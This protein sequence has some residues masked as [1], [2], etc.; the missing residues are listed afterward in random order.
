MEKKSVSSNNLEKIQNHVTIKD[1][2]ARAGV[3]IGTVDRALHNRG[4]ISEKTKAAV[5]QAAEELNYHRNEFARSLRIQNKISLLAIYQGEPQAYSNHFTAGFKAEQANLANYGLQLNLL[6][7]RSLE[8]KDI[9]DEIENIDMSQYDGIMLNAGGPELNSFINEAIDRNIVVTTFN[10]DS[11][12]SKRLFFVG[13]NHYRA[14]RLAGELTAKLL[15]GEGTV[16]LFSGLS[17]VYALNER[18]RGFSSLLQEDYPTVKIIKDINHFDD[19]NLRD[20]KAEELLFDGDMPDAI[21]CNS[22]TGA[23]PVCQLLEKY[24]VEKRPVVIGYDENE[25]LEQM[26]KKGF[27]TAILHQHPQKQA[28]IVLRELFQ[29]LYTG[30]Q[31]LPLDEVVRFMPTIM[32]KGNIDR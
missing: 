16:G 18:I 10:S 26:L 27:C 24:K 3:S 7:A 15:R 13:E 4:R 29:F 25:E 23:L 22:A 2:S 20:R 21:F 28:R 19:W 9:L 17:T 30:K 14:G 31:T 12:N 6:R 8:S 32:L 5:L 11:P 1:I